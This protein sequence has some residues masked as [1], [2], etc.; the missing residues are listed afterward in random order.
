[1][2]ES[3]KGTALIT[4]ASS[5]IGLEL[6]KV[7][8]RNGHNLVL[9]ARDEQRLTLVAEELKAIHDITC[10]VISYDLSLPTSAGDLYRVLQAKEITV[11]VLV[12]NAGFGTWGKFWELDEEKEKSEMNLNMVNLA[13]LTKYVLREM[14]ARGE[15]KIMNVAS[16][17]AFL[18]GPKMSVYYATKAFVRSFSE[19]LS[20]EVK[21]TGITVSTLC[22]GPTE[23][24]F[25]HHAGMA[26]MHLL[27]SVFM[28]NANSVAESAYAGMIEGKRII[29]PGVLN[30][31]L[32]FCIR[33]LPQ[34]ILLAIV[35]SLHKRRGETTKEYA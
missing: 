18:P 28:M 4:G 31:L 3:L 20:E 22:P 35:H 32:V 7:F 6:A 17:A 23:T 13:L 15:G 14:I 12:N 16:V 25:Q 26:N 21:G 2:S 5:G 24:E 19:A 30:K 29:I 8:A 10:Q 11:E 27:K 33:F 34:K 9:V 1:M